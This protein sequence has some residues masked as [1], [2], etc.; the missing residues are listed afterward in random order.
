M[1]FPQFLR[2]LYLP[3]K[4]VFPWKL[5]LL[6]LVQSIG[7]FSLFRFTDTIHFKLIETGNHLHLNIV[8]VLWIYPLVVWLPTFFVCCKRKGKAPAK[9]APPEEALHKEKED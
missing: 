5:M 3:D 8:P 1:G 6:R 4:R 2:F 9:E 7:E